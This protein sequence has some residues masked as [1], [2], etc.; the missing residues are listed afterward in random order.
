MSI[1]Q[2]QRSL[3][4]YF[5]H[6]V[7]LNCVIEEIQTNLQDSAIFGGMIRDFSLGFA[8]TF[9]SDIDIVCTSPSSE[10]YNLIKK[11]NPQRNKFGGFRFYAEMQLFDIW[12]LENTWAIKEGLV[13]GKKIEDLC[14]TT[15]FSTDAVIYKLSK[16]K[17]SSLEDFTNSISSRIL[18]INL[19]SNPYPEKMAIRAILMAIHKKMQLSSTLCEYILK[20][21]HHTN[22]NHIIRSFIFQLK[23]HK[24][25]HTDTPFSYADQLELWPKLK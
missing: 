7:K 1:V 16:E 10:I 15:F 11:Y 4:N 20:N 6:R 24:R 25:Y 17:I 23:K 21:T 14:K 19:E 13:E 2:T 18:D 3:S 22:Q 9:N 8:R 5:G 12:S